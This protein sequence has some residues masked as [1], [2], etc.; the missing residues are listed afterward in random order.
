MHEEARS[1]SGRTVDTKEK[2]S[3]GRGQLRR[4]FH[5]SIQKNKG[6]RSG[7]R[8]SGMDETQQDLERDVMC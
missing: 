5:Y 2:M 7:N 1:G 3:A 8:T 4:L 6:C